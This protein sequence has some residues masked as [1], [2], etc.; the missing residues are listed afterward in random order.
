[1]NTTTLNPP[2]YFYGWKNAAFLFFIFLCGGGFGLGGF[3]VIFPAMVKSLD[4]NRGTASIAPALNTL[5]AGFLIPLAAV[6]IHK[7]GSKK[8]ILIGMTIMFTGIVLLGTVTSQIWHWTIIW[9]IFLSLG[10]TFGT[11]LPIQTM[12]MQWFSKYRATA[13]GIVMA[14]AA[15]GSFL[16]Q[17]FYTWIIKST[18]SWQYGWL[19]GS[20]FIFIAFIC[21]F[22]IVGKPED[23]NQFPDGINPDG[24]DA[25]HAG[26][27]T[28][29]TYKTS[30]S[31]QL[32]EILKTPAIW[33]ITIVALGYIMP[34]IFLTTHGVLH[35]TDIGYTQMQAALILSL[36]IGGAGLIRL[37]IGWIGDQIEPRWIITIAMGMMLLTFIGLWRFSHFNLIITAG[38]VFGFSYGSMVIIHPTL[39]GN[40]FGADM[41]AGINAA[42]AP[43][44]IVF[45]ACVPMVSGYIFEKTT[46]YD[47]PFIILILIMAGAFIVSF[48]L[49]PPKKNSSISVL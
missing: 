30:E 46:S 33:L 34:L 37:P 24:T 21:A 7:L 48:L 26:Q 1:M 25:S 28:G 14:G 5:L 38:I 27:T 43:L 22:F 4:W 17:P 23:L 44:T 12:V 47:W 18:G 42:I 15:L 11:A 29:K 13:L 10:F 31:W 20:I 35:F 49:I 3:S 39:V 9:G 16:A 2:P 8:T 19:I 41:F 40:Y 32:K 6:S 36:V 45:T